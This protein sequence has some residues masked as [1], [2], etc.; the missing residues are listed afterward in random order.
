MPENAVIAELPNS[1]SNGGWTRSSQ[2]TDKGFL[3]NHTDCPNM[4]S[5]LE[6][7]N[8]NEGLKTEASL[9]FVN[10]TEPEAG[11]TP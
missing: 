2:D 3:S 7:V 6:S 4:E 8:N 9:E 1:N 5:N 10:N 11:D